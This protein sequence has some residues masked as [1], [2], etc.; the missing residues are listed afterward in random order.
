MPPVAL[1][2]HEY[3]VPATVDDNEMPVVPPEQIACE[4]GVAVATGNRLTVTT[5]VPL[6]V[7]VQFAS[8]TEVNE[9]VIG[10]DGVTVIEYGDVL[11]LLTG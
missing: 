2:V 10:L 1:A 6:A 8:E 3:V 5:A 4:D 7:P 11:I 9:Y